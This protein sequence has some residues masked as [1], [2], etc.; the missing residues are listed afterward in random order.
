[1][2]NVPTITQ[3]ELCLRL[4][5]RDLNAP[6]ALEQLIVQELLYDMAIHDRNIRAYWIKKGRQIERESRNVAR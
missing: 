5:L 6:M 4:R 2:S 1:M 3:M